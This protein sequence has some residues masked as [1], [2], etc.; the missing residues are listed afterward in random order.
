MGVLGPIMFFV[1]SLGLKEIHE[2]KIGDFELKRLNIF[3][4]TVIVNL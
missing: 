4:L 3:D 1:S 2:N